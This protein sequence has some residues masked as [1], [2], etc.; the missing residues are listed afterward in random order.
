MN[1]GFWESGILYSS[2]VKFWESGFWRFSKWQMQKK[3]WNRVNICQ[4]SIKWNAL[5]KLSSETRV[6]TPYDITRGTNKNSKNSKNLKILKFGS[7]WIQN[8][9]I[10]HRKIEKS[11]IRKN[12]KNHR[13][14]NKTTLG[15]LRPRRSKHI[16]IDAA[17]R[18]ESIYNL[19][20]PRPRLLRT[21]KTMLKSI[22][23]DKCFR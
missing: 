20:D 18:A 7:T 19:L 3:N 23:F 15:P 16:P 17:R 5:C 8:C 6:F 21:Q 11:I 1:K 13:E 2:P 12:T 10:K 14:S 4:R 9:K 22:K